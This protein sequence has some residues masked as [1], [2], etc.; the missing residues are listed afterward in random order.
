MTLHNLKVHHSKPVKEWLGKNT[1]KI[2]VFDLTSYSPELNQNKYINNDFKQT[3]HGNYG[4]VVQSK[5]TIHYKTISHTRHL[6]KILF[7]VV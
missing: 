4:G 5:A 6:K 1:E 7:K 2:G 3:A